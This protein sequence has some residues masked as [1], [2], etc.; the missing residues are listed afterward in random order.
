MKAWRI[1][2]RPLLETVLRNHAN[3]DRIHL[4]LVLHGPR[5]V[6]KTTL[7][8]HRLLPEWN[9]GPHF[10]AYVDLAE[11][12]PDHHPTHSRSA[13]WTSWSNCPSPPTLPALHSRLESSLESIARAGVRL[14]AITSTQILSALTKYHRPNTAL[15]RILRSNSTEVISD[16][17]STSALWD[18]AVLA[19]SHRSDP[20]EI[21]AA[22]GMDG[23]GAIVSSK[24]EASYYREGVVA[25][26]LAKEVIG[27]QR[28]WRAQAV[29]HLNR[30]GLFSWSLANSCTD[31]PYLL[32]YMLTDSAELGYFQPK[33][34]INNIDVLRNAI[35]VD[36][37]FVCAS[38]YHDSL[39]FRIIALGAR[40]QCLPVIL[41]TSDSYYSYQAHED[42]GSPGIFI[43][44]EN[45][46]WTPQEAELHMV[47]DYF[48]A[49]E[50][51]LITDVLGSNTRHLFE[52]YALK[53]S[54]YYQKIMDD[55]ESAF[56]DILDAYL[57]Y[58]QV[59][60]VNPSME[61]ALKLLQKFALD[62][63]NGTIS[64]DKLCFGAPWRHPPRTDNPMHRLK[65]AKVQLMDFV[66]SLV[67]TEFG[68][69]YLADTSFEIFDDPS[70]VAMLEVGLLYAQREPAII[71]P[72]SV[73]IQRCLV[74]W[75]V[76]ERMQMSFW[77]SIP[78]LWQRIVRGR[79]YRHLMMQVGYK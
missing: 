7:F 6:G 70:A 46:G 33:L 14:G 27:V 19:L 79:S 64:K 2:P 12:I 36:D 32:L 16:K 23:D 29:A 24:E 71:R 22:L 40:Q 48:T 45:F 34:V 68:V 55:K 63:Q 72:V 4:P 15:R 39:L 41:V 11:S 26:R 60:E 17:I 52:L 38:Q 59:A 49:S 18:R 66:M 35:L 8:L 74:R 76:Q 28:A 3:H 44:R 9:E 21:D 10:T 53:Q 51:T 5:G 20:R 61:R 78:F 37:S 31:W 57:A 77:E 54:S 42:F 1:N 69:N 62:A 30:N 67:N 75:L 25:L 65:W 56:E 58:L 50:W 47:S 73:G 43:S 13:P